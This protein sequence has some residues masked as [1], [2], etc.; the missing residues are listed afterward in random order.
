MEVRERYTA[1]VVAVNATVTVN[2]N[3]IGGFLCKTSGT[4]TAIDAN[5]NTI[6]NAFPVT[7]GTYFPMPFFMGSVGG[8][9]IA[10]GG[11]SGTLAN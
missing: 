4:V 3:M 9:F 7:A 8:S 5:G 6:V 10:A 1:T 2:S 11:A